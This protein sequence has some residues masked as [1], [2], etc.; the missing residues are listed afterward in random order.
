[1]VTGYMETYKMNSNKIRF[2]EMHINMFWGG[3][4]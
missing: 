1:M 4:W 2:M 3:M